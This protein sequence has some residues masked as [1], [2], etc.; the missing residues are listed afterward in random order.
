M[1]AR[2]AAVSGLC[3]ASGW[4]LSSQRYQQSSPPPSH[5]PATLVVMSACTHS[6]VHSRNHPPP[7]PSAPAIIVTWE[8]LRPD[9]L[10]AAPI[11]LVLRRLVTHS[12]LVL[13]RLSGDGRFFNKFRV[14]WCRFF[15]DEFADFLLGFLVSFSNSC[16]CQDL[17][18]APPLAPS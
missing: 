16:S 7:P 1:V 11:L 8:F 4:Y 15:H 17:C 2:A 18:F 3:C 10:G 12:D 5:R 6:C 13:Q 14:T 9:A